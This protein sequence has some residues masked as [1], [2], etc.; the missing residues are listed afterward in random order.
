[1]GEELERRGRERENKQGK[2]ILILVFFRCV[3]ENIQ[4]YSN[5]HVNSK[6]SNLKLTKII[7]N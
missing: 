2:G 6:I 3:K 1:M 5:C 7:K 4:Y